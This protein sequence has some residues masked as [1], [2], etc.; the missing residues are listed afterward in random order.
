MVELP[1]FNSVIKFSEN[2]SISIKKLNEKI[3]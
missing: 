3:D 2:I 1:Q